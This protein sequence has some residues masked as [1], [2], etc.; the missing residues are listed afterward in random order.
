MKSG[1]SVMIFPEGTRSLNGEVG[2]FNTWC[3]YTF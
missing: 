3:I 1:S 2:R